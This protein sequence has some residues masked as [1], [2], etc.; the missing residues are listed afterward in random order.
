[1]GLR[2][3]DDFSRLVRS[4]PSIRSAAAAARFVPHGGGTIKS[5]SSSSV[6][7]ST[8]KGGSKGS[9][10]SAAVLNDDDDHSNAA[11]SLKRP[12]ALFDPSERELLA[13][14]GEDQFPDRE[15]STSTA[16]ASLRLLGLRTS[17]TCAGVLA[18]AQ[19]VEKLVVTLDSTSTK[20]AAAEVAVRRGSDLLRFLDLRSDDLKRSLQLQHGYTSRFRNR[21]CVLLMSTK[22]RSTNSLRLLS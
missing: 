7:G 3:L 17:L 11:A 4:E 5:G 13:L 1:V 10:A 12:D 15:H 21:K 18:S 14:L 22:F 6:G 16:L 9:S 19:S 8:K 2:L 20:S